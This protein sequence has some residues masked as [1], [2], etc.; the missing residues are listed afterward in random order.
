MNV[1]CLSN[2]IEPFFSSPSSPTL[3]CGEV[4]KTPNF[5]LQF[6]ESRY[7]PHSITLKK[8]VDSLNFPHG[9]LRKETKSTPGG[10]YPL[11]RGDTISSIGKI[12]PS[13]KGA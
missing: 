11:D 6:G 1:Y 4:R 2:S 5:L 8:A 9:D 12:F 3:E 10:D 13:Q 7:S